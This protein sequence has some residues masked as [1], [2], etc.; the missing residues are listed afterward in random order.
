MASCTKKTKVRRAIKKA[1]A[2][3]TRKRLIRN[4]GTTPP[5]L[6]LLMPKASGDKSSDS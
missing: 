3:K 2:G 6:S 1:K 5:L 4:H